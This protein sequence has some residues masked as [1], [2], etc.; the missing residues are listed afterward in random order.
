[1]KHNGPLGALGADGIIASQ[2]CLS[3]LLASQ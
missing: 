3:K 2:A 1:M